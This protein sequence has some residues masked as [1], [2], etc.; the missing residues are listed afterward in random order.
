M[1]PAGSI[2]STH[3]YYTIF[4][5][6]ASSETGKSHTSSISYKNSRDLSVGFCTLIRARYA[7][8]IGSYK[9]VKNSCHLRGSLCETDSP[10]TGEV[11]RSAR[12][13]ARSPKVTEGETNKLAPTES[14]DLSPTRF[15]EA[16][17]QRGSFLQHK[18]PHP[19]GCGLRIYFIPLWRL[20][21]G[22]GRCPPVPSG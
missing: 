4:I 9:Q 1:P 2:C 12:G 13:G 14:K 5:G 18:K 6:I 22:G 20:H 7:L 19:C 11:A 17:S 21:G 10:D 8:H 3:V 15:A 16:P